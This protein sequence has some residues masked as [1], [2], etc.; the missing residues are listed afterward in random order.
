MP[1]KV[2]DIDVV[3]QLE[4]GIGRNLAVI[5]LVNSKFNNLVWFSLNNMAPSWVGELWRV[6]Q[7]SGWTKFG[8]LLSS[9]AALSATLYFIYKRCR[10]DERD[11]G[12]VDVNKVNQTCLK[13][14]EL[15]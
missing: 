13:Y 15:K 6:D 2:S 10:G 3:G 11:E 1:A 7:W 4:L 14:R 5:Y 8:F 9:G 12:F